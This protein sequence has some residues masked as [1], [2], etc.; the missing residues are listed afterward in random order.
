MLY[1]EIIKEGYILLIYINCVDKYNVFLFDM[2]YDMGK[3]LV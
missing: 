3:V 2:F 1:I